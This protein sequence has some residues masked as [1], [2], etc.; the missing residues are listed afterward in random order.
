MT[1]TM[2][3]RIGKRQT[4][5]QATAWYGLAAIPAAIYFY[6]LLSTA[7]NTPFHDDFY[8]V[9]VPL[10]LYEEGTTLLESLR[11]LLWQYHQHFVV[12]DRIVYWFIHLLSP[13]VHFDYLIAIGNA[14]LLVF[15]WQLS[16]ALKPEQLFILPC[17]SALL[18][19]LYFHENQ[20]WA[21]GS[22]QQ[23]TIM[24]FTLA[25]LQ[26]LDAG[27][28]VLAAC[29]FCWLAVFT[30][31][32]EM[33]L[34]PLGFLLLFHNAFHRYNRLS[35]SE[36]LHDRPLIIWT[37]SSVVCL[38][39]FFS[40]ENISNINR[41]FELHSSYHTDTPL[42]DIIVNFLSSLASLPWRDDK[43]PMLG[44][45]PGSLHLL[46]IIFLLRRG[47][48]HNRALALMLLFCVVSLLSAS[49]LRTP[50]QGPTAYVSRY[51]IFTTAILCIE[52]VLAS[53]IFSLRQWFP[54]LFSSAIAICGYS[55]YMH[56]SEVRE[57]NTHR[58]Q[59]T[60]EWFYSGRIKS[61][62]TADSILDEAYVRGFYNPARD[63][64]ADPTLPHSIDR[65][66]Q[67]PQSHATASNTLVQIYTEP[68]S[69]AILIGS[70]ESKQFLDTR[71]VTIWFCGKQS[72]RITLK[73]S[74][75]Q[76]VLPS[77]NWLTLVIVEKSRLAPD[78]YHLLMEKDGET[79]AVTQLAN[80]AFIPAQR[81]DNCEAYGD[82]LE[83]YMPLL[84]NRYCKSR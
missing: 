61:F 83:E 47:W 66:D 42:T 28:S 81:S 80:S 63:L 13:S 56:A 72:Y 19:N 22:L 4:A 34:I 44:L 55:Y 26:I 78:S 69:R 24:A 40:H 20:Y 30:Q 64:A 51:K 60:L 23:L 73:A 57:Q 36:L 48:Q 54:L 49:L 35:A 52:L 45:L 84:F 79:L 16:R 6:F 14:S 59:K 38:A 11:G 67:C 12:Y 2:A 25:A 17:V 37:V 43:S 50:H 41:L 53:G 8:D 31:S 3:T 39:V 65:V 58:Q 77:K 5:L 10:F 18:F 68:D 75:G 62:A 1:G 74:P 29:L 46:L 82:K 27:K 15:L 7:A 32:N 76:R 71:R 21:M 9:F 33:L 70:S